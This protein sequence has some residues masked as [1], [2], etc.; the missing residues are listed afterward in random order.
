MPPVQGQGEV[1][2]ELDV[3]PPQRQRRWTVLLRALLAIPH[4]VVLVIL[5]I[6]M[7]V[8]VVIAWFGALAMG[9]LPAWCAEFLGGYLEYWTRVSSYL[10]LLVDA[11]PPFWPSSQHYP[12][13]IQLTPGRLNRA[14]VLFRFIL[15]IPAYFMLSF[16]TT[17]WGL[18]ALFFWVAVLILGRTPQPV[19]E[20]SAA[21]VRYGMRANAYWMMLTSAYPKRLFGDPAAPFAEYPA[22]PVSGEYPPAV[23]PLSS[24]TRPFLLS[25]GGKAL[26]IVI[27]VL[28]VL[29]NV[30]NIASGMRQNPDLGTD[31]TAAGQN[32]A[33]TATPAV[34]SA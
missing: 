26:L 20:A 32:T 34:V 16:V 22:A 13:S 17:G 21:V 30:V 2:P 12:V 24:S 25:S 8:V 19:F 10:Y 28:G 7:L 14:A 3:F 18:L 5:S 29:Y 27:I 9:R 33:A 4:G 6:A 15:F 1:L 31:S 11:Y 23:S